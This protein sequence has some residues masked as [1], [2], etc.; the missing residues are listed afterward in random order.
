MLVI[1]SFSMEIR[2]EKPGKFERISERNEYTIFFILF[3]V[4]FIIFNK[5]ECKIKTKIKNLKSVRTKKSQINLLSVKSSEYF[6]ITE[7]S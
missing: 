7:E 3:S 1:R 5:P 6:L 4:Y 2:Q